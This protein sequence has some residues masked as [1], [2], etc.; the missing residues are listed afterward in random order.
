MSKKPA[1]L[2]IQICDSGADTVGQSPSQDIGLASQI[3]ERLKPGGKIVLTC[4]EYLLM[5][6]VVWVN[7]LQA[8][9]GIHAGIRLIAISPVP[10]AFSLLNRS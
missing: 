2:L 1:D 8:D 6:S 9:H 5:A 4:G 7:E 10:R 3:G